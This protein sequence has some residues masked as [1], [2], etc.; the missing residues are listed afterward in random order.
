MSKRTRGKSKARL[1]AAVERARRNLPPDVIKSEGNAP[2]NTPENSN[3]DVRIE[4]DES[5][6]KSNAHVKRVATLKKSS[7]LSLLKLDKWILTFP[8]ILFNQFLRCGYII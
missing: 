2:D 1:N 7:G 4:R 6:E 3:A 8:A 5:E